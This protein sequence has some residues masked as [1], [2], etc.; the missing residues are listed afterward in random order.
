MN[1]KKWT[2][3]MLCRAGLIA[4]L[5]VVVT[6]SFGEL[7]FFALQVRPAEALTLLPLFYPEAIAGLYI[8]CMIANLTSP[9]LIYDVF[10]G[11]LA[12]LLAGSLTYVAGRVI[13]NDILKVAV[14]GVFPVLC[15]AFIIPAVMLLCDPTSGSYWALALS[16][17]G[18]EAVWVYALGIP[19][20]IS[21]NSMITRGVRAV[22]PY[23]RDKKNK[24]TAAVNY[25]I[26]E[27]K[28]KVNMGESAEKFK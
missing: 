22:M 5:Y 6:L 4:A 24:T 28:D 20:F 15:N 13:K 18:C 2:T 25:D 21:L 27:E 14:G 9:F 8:G 3:L 11:S 10:I 26:C 16:I 23:K 19:L 7:S 1:L 17:G 12:T